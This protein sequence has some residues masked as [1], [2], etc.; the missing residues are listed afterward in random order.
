MTDQSQTFRIRPYGDRW[1]IVLGEEVVLVSNSQENAK[2]V[3]ATADD[4]L[5]R[6]GIKGERR[7]FSED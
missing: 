1:A 6:S 7:S 5:H 2:A 3:V 4:V